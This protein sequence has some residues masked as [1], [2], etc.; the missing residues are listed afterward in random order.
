MD[1]F[2]RLV[3]NFFA[4]GILWTILFAAIKANALGAKI[5]AG[6]QEFGAN[7]FQT[8]PVVPI[9]GMEGKV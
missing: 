1:R 7:V 9:P 2:S 4:I 3:V 5:G 6:I 8:M